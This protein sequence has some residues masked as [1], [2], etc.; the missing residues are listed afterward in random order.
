MPLK[1]LRNLSPL[2]S[3]L[4]MAP[5]IDIVFQLIT[6]FIFALNTEAQPVTEG[7]QPPVDNEGINEDVRPG[8]LLIEVDKAGQMLMLG[9]DLSKVR[10]DR[11][12]ALEAVLKSLPQEAQV[13]IRADQ[14]APYGAI[15]EL[16]ELSN[17]L[18]RKKV[19]LRLRRPE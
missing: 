11:N 15:R 9:K 14:D 3:S 10:A 8:D 4:P 12:S 16:M 18:G 19:G 1:R 13:V 2:P 6:F 5:M 7:I 17:R